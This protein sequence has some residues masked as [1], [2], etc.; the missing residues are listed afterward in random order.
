M[1]Q[2]LH[3]SS[4][5]LMEDL[6]KLDAFLFSGQSAGCLS[7]CQDTEFRSSCRIITILTLLSGQRDDSGVGKSCPLN[8]DFQAS[9]CDKS[10]H[11]IATRSV[12][13][14]RFI[15]TARRHK[16]LK[17]QSCSK[18][19]VYVSARITIS[20]RKEYVSP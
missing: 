3:I 18:A 14:A 6:N 13:F 2:E 1:Y 16:I 10:R 4:Y 12:F 8:L 19:K 15:L 11:V 7:F 5:R 20:S 9:T 17:V